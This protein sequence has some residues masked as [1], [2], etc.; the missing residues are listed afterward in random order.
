MT[1]ARDLSKLLST[2]NGKIAGANLDVSFENI[3]DTGTAGTKVASGTT[4]Q[5]GSTA[6]QIRF[7]TTT[8]LAE[9]YTGT[10][11]KIIDSPPTVT[12]VSPLEVESD[13][14]G[15]ITFTI[16][17]SNFQSGAVAK[18]IGNDGTE[19]TASTTTI[20]SGSSI[21][22]VIAR[23]SFV[24]AKE[25]YDVRII[26]AS[27]LSGTL[28]N[29]INVDVSP[30]WS[31]ASG[32]LGTVVELTSINLSATATDVDSDT[33]IYS[34]LSGS[35]PSGLTL[36]TST[37]AITGTAPDVASETT[38][39]FT[40]RATANSKTADRAFTITVRP[41]IISTFT[42]TGAE[43]TW[44]VP[45][46]VTSA[47]IKAWGAGG[48]SDSNGSGRYGA[49]GGFAY[50]T[51]TLTPSTSMK[52]I[53]GQGGHIGA[54]G[55]SGGGGGG[56]SGFFNTSVSQNNALLIAGAG[57]GAG[58]NNDG[59][60][61]G[62]TNGTAGGGALSGGGGTQSAG[63]VNGNSKGTSYSDIK[64]TAGSAL[65]GGDGGADLGAGNGFTAYA[66]G[67]GGR[68]GHE[69]GGS[70]GGGGGGGGYFG[71]GGGDADHFGQNT[72]GT[73]G[74]GG[75][76]GSSYYNPTYVSNATL[77]SGSTTNSGGQADTN[78]VSDI[79]MAGTSRNG[80]HGRLVI[81]Y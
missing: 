19:I 68:G 15:N 46:G 18:F 9:Y 67:G 34:V 60:V 1:K 30:T 53:V 22:A 8:G 13:V 49:G 76:G 11:F 6:G 58:D 72:G 36:N 61:G 69:P 41:P 27:G 74:H 80:G 43:Q 16:T 47:L 29:Q 78:W 59:G 26:N 21:S 40:L 50:G 44:T 52:I 12:V 54:H 17:G 66:F 55:G 3:S 75:G 38:Y 73:G 39:S 32:S 33:I 81:I 24:N 20:N 79:G 48:G 2:A 64:P 23:S 42:Y 4:A 5:R 37:G 31:T 45:S 10:D 28:D 63:G 70:Q 25:P 65:Q 56:Y 57:G 77:T 35:L 62:G 51:V 71:G 14:G 7:N